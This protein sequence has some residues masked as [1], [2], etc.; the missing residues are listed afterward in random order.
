MKDALSLTITPPNPASQHTQQCE[1]AELQ[2]LI[3]VKDTLIKLPCSP[4][5]EP[6]VEVLSEFLDLAQDGGKID[7]GGLKIL[8][9]AARETLQ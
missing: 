6:I 3:A 8:V 9:H 4:E 7:V 2:Q 1:E 5:V